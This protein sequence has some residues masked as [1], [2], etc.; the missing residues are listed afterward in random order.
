MDALVGYR[1]IIFAFVAFMS[2]ALARFGITID[3]DGVTNSIIT[4]GSIALAIWFKVKANQRETALKQEVA[5][6]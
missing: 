5:K 2:E 3:A 1:S 6:Q 4:L